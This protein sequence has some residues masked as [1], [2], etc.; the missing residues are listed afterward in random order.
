MKSKL[1]DSKEN[2]CAKTTL[3]G[4]ALHSNKKIKKTVKKASSELTSVN[5]V[6]KQKKVSFQVMEQTV[7]L[8]MD[9]EQN[10]AQAADDMTLVNVKIAKELVVRR[11]IES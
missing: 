5:E 3:L 7:V 10:V 2:A 4:Q 11:G 1:K 6:L 8:N 9:V